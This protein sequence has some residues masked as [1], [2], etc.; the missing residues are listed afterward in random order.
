M[1]PV[2]ICAILQ[3]C[4][5]T[6]RPG[7]AAL[8]SANYRPIFMLCPAPGRAL[9]A[10]GEERRPAGLDHPANGRRTHARHNAA[11]HGAVRE[12]QSKENAK[13]VVRALKEKARQGFWNG[14]C[15]RSATAWA[16]PSNAAR[17]SRRSWDRPAA[18]WDGAADLPCPAF[19]VLFRVGGEG[20]RLVAD[21]YQA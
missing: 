19:A 4:F 9:A 13:H 6:T 21:I 1:R 11:D 7:A 18:R 20:V 16:R 8:R 15:L 10:S 5:G 17:R 3:Q 12:Y 14:S 2:G